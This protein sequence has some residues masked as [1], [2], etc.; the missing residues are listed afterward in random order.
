MILFLKSHWRACLIFI[1]CII[2]FFIGTRANHS[3]AIVSN[4]QSIQVKA[5]EKKKNRVK[6]KVTNIVDRKADGSVKEIK[7][8]ATEEEKIDV[9]NQSVERAS[10]SITVTVP[11]KKYYLGVD[12][13]NPREPSY[14]I[15]GG[16]R[17][18]DSPFFIGTFYRVND[19]TFGL[20]VSVEF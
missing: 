3:K 14:T 2:S 9:K 1:V 15:R 19:K 12:V 20:S 18:G 7:I 5:T 16:A 17:V 11:L 13:S 4:K 6:T 8:V 10:E